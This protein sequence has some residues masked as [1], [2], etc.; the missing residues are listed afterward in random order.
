MCKCKW[1]ISHDF[2]SRRV[3]VAF[4]FGLCWLA[5]WLALSLYRWPLLS[6]SLRPV[7]CPVM[8]LR[9]SSAILLSVHA[10]SSV[11]SSTG[12]CASTCAGRTAPC[13]PVAG[14]SH[15]DSNRYLPICCPFT[16]DLCKQ[17]ISTQRL[18]WLCFV[19]ER[20]PQMKWNRGKMKIN[21]Q[22]AL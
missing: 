18:E 2:T 7:D 3:S 5:G 22:S 10:E 12:R 4:L 19:R 21:K 20:P 1:N 11:E 17:L 16:C 9:L 6:L 8:V 13:K 14:V 15:P